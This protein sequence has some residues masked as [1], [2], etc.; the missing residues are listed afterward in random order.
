MQ[1]LRQERT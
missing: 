1:G